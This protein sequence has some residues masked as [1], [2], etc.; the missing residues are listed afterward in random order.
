MQST[1]HSSMHDL[2]S[3]STQGCAMMYVTSELPRRVLGACSSSIAVEGKYRAHPVVLRS[4]PGRRDRRLSAELDDTRRRCARVTGP[5]VIAGGRLP[6]IT[7]VA[8]LVDAVAGGMRHQPGGDLPAD[9]RLQHLHLC[10]C[11]RRP[12][13]AR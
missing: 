5:A 11:L 1:G 13:A 2:S 7:A 4:S 9:G 3:T 6:L 10:L 12:P 8:H